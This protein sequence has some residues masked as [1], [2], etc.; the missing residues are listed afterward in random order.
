MFLEK[1]NNLIDKSM[2]QKL[3]IIAM[4]IVSSIASAHAGLNISGTGRLIVTAGSDAGAHDS[5]AFTQEGYYIGITADK[6]LN[7]DFTISG[8][9]WFNNSKIITSAQDNKG[10]YGEQD[11]INASWDKTSMAITGKLGKFEVTNKG[12]VSDLSGW[13]GYVAPGAYS[14]DGFSALAY[15]GRNRLGDYKNQ[16]SLLLGYGKTDIG[17]PRGTT[18]L[19]YYS[20]NLNGFIFGMSVMESGGD[21][22]WDAVKEGK[23]TDGVL[24]G[25]ITIPHV[26]VEGAMVP[27]TTIAQ[28]KK[29]IMDKFLGEPETWHRESVAYGI[30]YAIQNLYLGYSRN[31]YQAIKRV[32]AVAGLEDSEGDSIAVGDIHNLDQINGEY[33]NGWKA[34]RR[35]IHYILGPVGLAYSETAKL[36]S[37]P[38]RGSVSDESARADKFKRAAQDNINTTYGIVFNYGA[39][40]IGYNY[41]SEDYPAIENGEQIVKEFG[42]SVIGINH[43]L[44][45]GLEIYAQQITG[46]GDSDP[47]KDGFEKN[48]EVQFGLKVSF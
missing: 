43:Q 41:Q 24:G 18:R 19:N 17:I 8:G 28:A 15:E 37:P 11:N 46:E 6:R 14:L 5:S 40:Q 45:E 38:I 9:V 26:E 23:A 4:L 2:K 36:Y 48:Q 10:Y 32:W 21:S 25:V 27:A 20:A 12:D 30:R 33:S 22:V 31:S 47:T 29:Y 3:I 39:G 16:N 13:A 42:T 1:H 34:E 35:Y 7:N 44:T